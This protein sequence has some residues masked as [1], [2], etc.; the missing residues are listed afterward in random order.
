MYYREVKVCAFDKV[1][2]L[3]SLKKERKKEFYKNAKIVW[4]TGLM[5]VVLTPKFKTQTNIYIH[6]I[7]T[8]KY[9]YRERRKGYNNNRCLTPLII[10]ILIIK[11]QQQR[12]FSIARKTV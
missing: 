12:S 8:H 11:R 1:R 9:I 6:Y 7:Y 4:N 2:M 3:E 5:T 10:I